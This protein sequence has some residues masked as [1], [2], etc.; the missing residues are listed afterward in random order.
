MPILLSLL[1]A[2]GYSTYY[3]SY[4]APDGG[5]CGVEGP[6]L[7]S[8]TVSNRHGAEVELYEQDVATCAEAFVGSLLN[9]EDWVS[10]VRTGHTWVVRGVDGAVV[11][12]FSVPLGVGVEHVEVIR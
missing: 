5:G 2:C 8:L 10:D 7:A 1:L 6:D 9:G 3:P 11:W 4:S 12:T